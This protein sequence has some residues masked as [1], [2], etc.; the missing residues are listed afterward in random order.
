[1][2]IAL[3]FLDLE[4][5]Q[6]L[7]GLR[8]ARVLVLELRKRIATGLQ[9]MMRATDFAAGA[10][11]FA[12]F[13]LRLTTGLLRLLPRFAAFAQKRLGLGESGGVLRDGG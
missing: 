4:F 6:A 1:M 13:F 7:R 3:R 11:G 5:E 12:Q 8:G 9:L 10:I 2:K